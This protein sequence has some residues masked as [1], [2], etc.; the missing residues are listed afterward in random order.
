MQQDKTEKRRNMMLNTPIPKLIPSMAIPTI[1]AMLVTAV[2][3]LADTFFVS[4]LGTGA[5]AAVGVNAGIDQFISMAGS[6]LAFGGNSYLARLLGKKDMDRA[7]KVLNTVFFSALG[8]GALVAIFG[9]LFCE[10]LVLLLGANEDCLAYSMDY[11]SWILLAAPFMA[12]SFVLNQSIR[13]EGSATYSMVGMAFGAILNIVLDPLF[14]FVFDKGVEGAAQATAISKLVSFIIL[15]F[16]YLRKRCMLKITPK[17]ICFAKDIVYEVTTVGS[18]SM[19]RT[20][21]ALLAS[22][23]TNNIAGDF[24][25]SALAAISVTNRV[26]MFPF[27]I[28]LGFGMGY[29]PVAGFNWGAKRYDRVWESTWFS[30][31]TAIVGS[32]VIGLLVGIFAEPCIR[33]FNAAEDE[34]ML[35]IGIL[36]LRSQCIVLSGHAVGMIANMLFAACGKGFSA[37]I[38]GISRQGF[39][40]LPVV[41]LM[42]YIW[43]VEGLALS[44]AV[45]DVLSMLVAAV[46]VWKLLKEIN[47][48]RKQ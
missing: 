31:I 28:I 7:E 29:Q 20:G 37:M 32:I 6:F 43:G 27:N 42:S 5:T 40:F 21:C 26:M 41:F 19:L 23:V 3:N 33:L 46:L 39:C 1:I 17:Q 16:P 24:S 10:P 13:S 2:Y 25:T 4:S 30:F 14:I 36:C 44:Q 34:Q 48:K 18:A 12:S 15:I 45:A 9:L 8:I 11:A 47:E 22:V 35:E 38:T